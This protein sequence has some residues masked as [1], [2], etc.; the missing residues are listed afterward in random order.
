M[1]LVYMSDI[2]QQYRS[3]KSSKWVTWAVLLIVGCYTIFLVCSK[4]TLNFIKRSCWPGRWTTRSPSRGPAV[5]RV[6]HRLTAFGGC[7]EPGGRS[8][9]GLLPAGPEHSRGSAGSALPTWGSSE[10]QLLLGAFGLAE[11]FSELHCNSRLSLLGPALLLSL[12]RGRI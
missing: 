4:V 12:C 9:P 6:P 5:G 3:Q 1:Y 10:E 2:S 11:I 7:P 8:S